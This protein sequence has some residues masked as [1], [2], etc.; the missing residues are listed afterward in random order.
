MRN[1]AQ[2]I[3]VVN[4]MVFMLAGALLLWVALTSRYVFDARR[5]SWLILALILVAWG[6]RGWRRARRIAVRRF[7]FAARIGGASLILVGAI[8]FSLAWVPL[9]WVSRLLALAGCL[10]ILRG[11]VSAA[12]LA[13]P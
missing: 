2:M 11:F 13:F 3:G 1:T 6:W 8:M 12:L 4:E 9:I 5:P 7:E 10:F